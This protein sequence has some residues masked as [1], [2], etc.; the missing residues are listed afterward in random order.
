MNRVRA[1]TI[2]T[3]R[4]HPGPGNAVQNVPQPQVQDV[5]KA[6]AL[7]DEAGWVDSDGDGYRDK[8]ING[9]KTKFE[10]TMIVRNSKERTDIC[11]LLRQNLR[12]IG[13]RL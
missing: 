9:Q 2:G 4:W 5:T 1:H 8:E 6:K 12:P 3:S 7:L 10:F 11:E 13:S